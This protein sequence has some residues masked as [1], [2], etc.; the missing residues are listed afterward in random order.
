MTVLVVNIGILNGRVS[1]Q[2]LI[3]SDLE[4]CLDEMPW[5]PL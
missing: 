2:R 4:L 1:A 5:V 3:L